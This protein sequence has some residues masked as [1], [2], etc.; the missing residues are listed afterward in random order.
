VIIEHLFGRSLV[1]KQALPQHFERFWE[2]PKL[3]EQSLGKNWTI[4]VE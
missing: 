2:I 4:V 1:S 3:F